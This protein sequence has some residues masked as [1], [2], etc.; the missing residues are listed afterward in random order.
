MGTRGLNAL[1]EALVGSVSKTVLRQ[2]SCP[3]LAVP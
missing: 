1:E 2:A 3:V